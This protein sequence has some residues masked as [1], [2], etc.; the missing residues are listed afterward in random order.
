MNRIVFSAGFLLFLLGST[1]HGQDTSPPELQSITIS[2]ASV[3]VTTASAAVTVTMNITDDSNGFSNGLLYFY[4]PDDSVMVVY[5]VTSGSRTGGDE[6]DGTYE[7]SVPIGQYAPPGTWRCEVYLADAVDGNDQRYGTGPGETAFPIPGA[8]QFTVVN[9]GVVDSD[10]PVV[11]NVAVSPDPVDT[12]TPQVIE[13]SCD[14]ADSPSGLSYG[15]V[16]FYDPDGFPVNELTTYFDGGSRVSGNANSGGY[17]VSVNLPTNLAPGTWTARV[18]GVDFIRNNSSLEMASFNVANSP[19]GLAG[20]LS[21]AT[22]ATQYAWSTSGDA[23]WSVV[24]GP[25]S[26]DGVDSA[27]SGAIGHGGTSTMSVTIDGEG[28]LRF[29]WKVSSESNADYLTVAVDGNVEDVISGEQD[30]AQVELTLSS[31]GPHEVTWTYEKDGSATAGQDAGWVDLVHFQSD[32]D[33]EAPVLQGLWISPNPVDVSTGDA[34]VTVTMELSDDANGVSEAN[35]RFYDPLGNYYDSYSVGAI[36]RISGNE[37]FGTYEVTLPVFQSALV[38]N[39]SFEAGFWRVEVDV[40]EDFGGTTYYGP[41]GDDFPIPGTEFFEVTAGD[42][43]DLPVLTGVNSITPNPVDVT[44]GTTSVLVNFDAAE[45]QDGIAYGNVFLYNTTY[46]FVANY[47]FDDANRVD[48]T[49]FAGT[50]QVSVPIPAHAAPGTWKLAFSLTDTNGQIREYSQYAESFPNPGEEEIEVLNSGTVD[51]TFPVLN[52]CS[53]TPGT[54]DTSGGSA[55]VTVNFNATDDNG[56]FSGI[57]L[58]VY[59]PAGDFQQA[60]FVA[61]G[62]PGGDFTKSFTMPMGSAEGTWRIRIGIRDAVG[63]QRYVGIYGDPMPVPG[64]DEFVVG[65]VAGT[66]FG[67]FVSTYSL[68]GPDAALGGNPDH[69]LFPNALELLLGLDPTV[70]NAADPAKYAVTKVGNELHLDFTIDPS[71]TVQTNGGRI[72]VDDGSGSAIHVIGQTGTN[73]A[74]DWVD[75]LPTHVT[76]TTY[77]VILPIGP[78]G[79]GVARL[80]VE[81]P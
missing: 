1:V 76:G 42:V 68:S 22:D 33:N 12:A 16:F 56:I 77:R 65:T 8:E 11:S 30:W 35:V 69:D 25:P 4:R 29:W 38:P 7:I 43:D 46:Q 14:I 31:G 51:T 66:T 19:G 36:D 26:W 5:S 61:A 39:G 3:D 24:Q 74:N 2:P 37:L 28:T 70:P 44:A 34:G 79:T 75:Q 50:Y 45:P 49:E 81:D 17:T 32:S 20:D 53:V 64:Q 52:S 48:G 59:D 62:V 78:G 47:F 6:L 27:R 80:A 55:L 60:L 10:G 72:E 21:D 18:Q 54:V 15:F 67:N 41:S 73:L 23:D 9:T 40:S 57:T 13:V 63:N 71:L 58:F